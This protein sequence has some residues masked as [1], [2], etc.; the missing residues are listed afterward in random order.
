M[1]GRK[2]V[3]NKRD[4]LKALEGTNDNDDVVIMIDDE[5]VEKTDGGVGE[6]LYP[7]YVDIVQV[8][9]TYISYNEIRLVLLNEGFEQ[10][11]ERHLRPDWNC[12]DCGDKGLRGDFE[13]ESAHP[14]CP[15]CNS[16]EVGEVE[17]IEEK[18][19]V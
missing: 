10:V 18:S 8:S 3:L 2:F 19:N 11:A 12:R 17:T 9:G 14:R 15:N 4:L 16:M 6:D 13:R 1:S 7:F 5:A